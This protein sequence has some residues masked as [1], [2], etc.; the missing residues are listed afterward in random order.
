MEIAKVKRGY[1]ANEVS[2]LKPLRDTVL[3]SDMNFETRITTSGIIIPGDDAKNSGIRPRWGKVFAV[4]P[5]QKEIQVGHWI[6]VA[7]GRWTRGIT[8]DIDGVR[9]TIR[10]VDN[11]DI[12]LSSDAPVTDD[13]M[14]D[15]VI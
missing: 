5:D 10:R 7:H 2:G 12:I 1:L 13:T 9:H 4:G 15:K 14:G 8:V 11:K 3:V 6:L